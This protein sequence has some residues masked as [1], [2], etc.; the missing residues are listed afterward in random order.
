[1]KNNNGLWGMFKN[2][3]ICM[4]LPENIECILLLCQDNFKLLASKLKISAKVGQSLGTA[5]YL[6]QCDSS[7]CTMKLVNCS[8]LIFLSKASLEK[9]PKLWVD[10]CFRLL[11]T[12]SSNVTV[13]ATQPRRNEM[14]TS[15]EKFWMTIFIPSAPLSHNIWAFL[16]HQVNFVDKCSCFYQRRSQ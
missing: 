5:L 14:V 3:V 1:M 4:F 2:E 11:D 15:L 8:A 16:N 9:I 10:Q 13:T 7:F 12:N 6:C